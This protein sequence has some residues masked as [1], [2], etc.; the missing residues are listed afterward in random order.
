MMAVWAECPVA[1]A[2]RF[3]DYPMH[4]HTYLVR[5]SVV[6]PESGFLDAEALRDELM[7]VRKGVDH[8]CLNDVLPSP[9]MEELARWFG[10]R[11]R[12]RGRDVVE[13]AVSRPLE[14]LGCVYRP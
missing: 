3:K 11:L 4:G 8:R 12:E 14:G 9:S 5:V 13:V 1:A 7:E 6:E 10:A 2:H